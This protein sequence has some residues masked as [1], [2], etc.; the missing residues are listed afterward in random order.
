MTKPWLELELSGDGSGCG[1]NDAVGEV[2]VIGRVATQS[3]TVGTT[4][5]L[6]II[7]RFFSYN[8]NLHD[9]DPVLV[10]VYLL[11][12]GGELDV[13]REVFGDGAG[14]EVEAALD[15]VSRKLNSISRP[16]STKEAEIK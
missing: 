7:H 1:D 15:A 2:D 3:I 12:F 5:M 13:A 8:L 10:L 6:V 14:E 16:I 4:E 11:H 9:S